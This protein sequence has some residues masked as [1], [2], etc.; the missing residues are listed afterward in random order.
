MPSRVQNIPVKRRTRNHIIRVP[1]RWTTC[2]ALWEEILVQMFNPKIKCRRNMKKE[3]KIGSRRTPTRR[4]QLK[5]TTR[6]P[7]LLSFSTI[8]LVF[9]NPKSH[10]KRRRI[11]QR[12]VTTKQYKFI[13]EHI[14]LMNNVFWGFLQNMNLGSRI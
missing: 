12:S 1:Q 7:I 2:R 6:F 13:F 8:P 3:R 14:L 10:V 11:S 5:S 9:R 4:R